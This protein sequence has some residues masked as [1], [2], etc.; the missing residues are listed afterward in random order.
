MLCISIKVLEECF[1]FKAIKSL[2]ARTDFS[3]CYDAL[4]GVQG[5]RFA[6]FTST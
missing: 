4:N 6:C 2:F 5:T 3:F 1:D